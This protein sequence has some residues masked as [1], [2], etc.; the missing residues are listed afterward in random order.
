MSRQ[1]PAKS[2]T[3]RPVQQG[4]NRGLV[5]KRKVKLQGILLKDFPGPGAAARTATHCLQICEEVII[6][7]IKALA[8]LLGNPSKSA[9]RGLAGFRMDQDGDSGDFWVGLV[10]SGLH[11][12][13]TGLNMRCTL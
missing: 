1:K 6:S 9:L 12:L 2:E 11:L 4:L 13:I 7:A 10:W 5:G 3:T 8:E